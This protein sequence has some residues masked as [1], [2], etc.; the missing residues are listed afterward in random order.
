MLGHKEG[1][2]VEDML[3]LGLAPPQ[4]GPF[5]LAVAFPSAF[6]KATIAY[7]HPEAGEVARPQVYLYKMMW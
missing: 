1:R 5:R 4:G 3:K 7:Y 6:G 2:L